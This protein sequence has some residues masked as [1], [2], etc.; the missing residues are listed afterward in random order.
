MY[1]IHSA[2]LESGVLDDRAVMA[3]LARLRG[4]GVRVGLSVSGP[5]QADVIR[6][7]LAVDVD[8][9]RLFQTVQASWNLLERSAG[10]ALSEA[11]ALGL[12]VIVK[13]GMANGRLAARGSATLSAAREAALECVCVR[14][15]AGRDALALAAILAEPWADVVLSGAATVEQLASNLHAL[16][17]NWDDEAAHALAVLVEEP[18]EYWTNRARLPWN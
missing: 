17:V 5:K 11:H 8:G 4:E 13:E 15:G 3:A 9:V 7:A 14:L 6:R 10:A 1:Q 12:G 16:D 2:T 18:A